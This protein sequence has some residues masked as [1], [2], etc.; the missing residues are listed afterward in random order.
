MP[1]SAK[2][3]FHFTSLNTLQGIL[4]TQGFWPQ[5]SLERFDLALP[6]TSSYLKSYI[7]MVCFCDLKLTQLSDPT[8]SLHTNHFGNYG[9]GFKKTWGIKKKISPVSYI[10]HNSVASNTIDKVI[11]TVNSSSVGSS[12]SLI[13]NLGEIVKFLKPYTG[14]YQKGKRFKREIT[15]YDEREWRYI[16]NNKKYQVFPFNNAN[17]KTIKYL[18][19]ELQKKSLKFNYSDIKYIIVDKDD[20][21]LILSNLFD[22]LKMSPKDK[23]NLLSRIMTFDQIKD[24]F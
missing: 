14:H 24:D 19:K 13:T 10:H 7:P 5:Y 20:D 16:P 12:T 8:V 15:Y 21:K 18:N 2:T 17:Q 6:S 9:L 4:T 23:T 3:L 1:V 22:N 11:T